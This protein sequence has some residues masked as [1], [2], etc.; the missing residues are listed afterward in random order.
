MSTKG[1]ASLL[2]ATLW[3]AFTF[4]VT[5]ILLVILIVSALL[6][7]R[8][9]NRALQRF[10]STQVIPTQFVLFTL[11]VIIGSAILYRD[12]ESATLDRVGKFVG[13]C[14]LTF[15]GV[16]LITSGR[17]QDDN[18]EDEEET[19]DEEEAIGLVDEERYEDRAKEIH[20]KNTRSQRDSTANVTF[21]EEELSPEHAGRPSQRHSRQQSSASQ[22]PQRPSNRSSEQ[23]RQPS[24]FEEAVSPLTENPW[25]W[26]NDRLAPIIAR[27]P[28]ETTISSPLLPSEARDSR[29]STPQNRRHPSV[30]SIDRPSA[31]SRRSMSRMVP[32]PL[33]SP[34]SSPLSAI[35][36][37]SLRRGVDSPTRPRRRLSGSGRT[38]SHKARRESS[39]GD[40]ILGTSPLKHIEQLPEQVVEYSGPGHGLRSQSYSAT[41][42]N[43]FR[44]KAARDK[45][46]DPDIEHTSSES[47]DRHE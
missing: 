18:D 43:F 26:P 1:V 13:G 11:S 40:A 32:G 6:Q 36:A 15:L 33:W 38:K 28:L 12:F 5:Y 29:P 34:L 9:V 2:S 41:L 45:G 35:V 37:D 10:D 24:T 8:Y 21:N 46:K 39:S 22:T 44:L 25:L 7:I 3:R 42:G 30:P 31:L 20:D 23:S 27:R 4:P 16:Y 17:S 47:D 14:V 19:H